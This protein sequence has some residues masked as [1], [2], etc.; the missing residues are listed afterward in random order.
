MPGAARISDALSRD[1]LRHRLGRPSPRTR[2]VIAQRTTRKLVGF[3]VMLV[4][5]GLIGSARRLEER[6]SIPD[7][8]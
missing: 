1:R 7:Q 2:P 3:G 4:A 8:D 5:M 6:A